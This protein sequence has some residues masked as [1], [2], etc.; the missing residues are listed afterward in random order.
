MTPGVD[1]GQYY[2]LGD[3]VLTTIPP[4]GVW[5]RGPPATG[6]H[7]TVPADVRRVPA[8]RR[9]ASCT[10]E[11]GCPRAGIGPDFWSGARQPLGAS[12]PG[13]ASRCPSSL[14]S[15]PD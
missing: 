7:D 4:R 15:P 5:G 1:C 2:R 13:Q 8:R 14:V 11:P 9:A 10:I 12:P 6:R 3:V